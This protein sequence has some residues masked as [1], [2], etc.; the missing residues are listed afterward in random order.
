[1]RACMCVCVTVTVVL[2]ICASSL[3]LWSWTLSV[4]LFIRCQY[5]NGNKMLPVF[6]QSTS[7]EHYSIEILTKLLLDTDSTVATGK[8]VVS[9]CNLY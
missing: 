8:R 5:Y 9:S 1:M 2:F 3:V 4:C 7:K 6:K